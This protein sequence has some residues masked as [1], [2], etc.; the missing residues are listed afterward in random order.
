MKYK[1]TCTFCGFENTYEVEDDYIHK[2]T[3]LTGK[4]IEVKMYK[5]T[6]ICEMCGEVLEE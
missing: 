4:S 6:F 3:T 2:L 1:I 5:K